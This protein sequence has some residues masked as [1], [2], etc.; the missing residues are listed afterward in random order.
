MNEYCLIWY[1]Y[2]CNGTVFIL[3]Q[4]QNSVFAIRINMGDTMLNE[5][6]Q[7]QTNNYA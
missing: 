2:V 7:T 4:E 6:S 5:I 1:V 3:K